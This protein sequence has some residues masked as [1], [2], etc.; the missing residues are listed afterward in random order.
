MPDFD[1]SE[2]LAT[3]KAEAEELL[4]QLSQ[5]LLS[6]EKNPQQPRVV[7]EL[8]RAA[9]TLKGASRMMEFTDIQNLA[10]LLEDA[11]TRMA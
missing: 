7:A 1:K 8:F 5:G 4:S 2:F 3:F 9:H 11:L 10:H 6:L